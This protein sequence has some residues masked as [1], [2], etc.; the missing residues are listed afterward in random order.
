M[1]RRTVRVPNISCGHCV[2]RIQKALGALEGVVE[3]EAD[4][5]SK[6]VTIEWGP[7]ATWDQIVATLTEIDYPPG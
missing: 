1:E 3:V 5:N 4:V 7:P 6:E 2:M